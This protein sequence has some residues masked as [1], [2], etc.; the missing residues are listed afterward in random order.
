MSALV[1]NLL[2]RRCRWRDGAAEI[3]L[4]WRIEGS[5]IYVMVVDAGGVLHESQ[6]RGLILLPKEDS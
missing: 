5:G 6:A 3:T 1:T 4:V 2:G